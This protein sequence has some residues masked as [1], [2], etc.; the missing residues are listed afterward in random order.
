VPDIK[1]KQLGHCLLQ[2][3]DARLLF[4]TLINLWL[5]DILVSSLFLRPRRLTYLKKEKKMTLKGLEE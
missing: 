4:L 2:L 3:H 5:P 1:S